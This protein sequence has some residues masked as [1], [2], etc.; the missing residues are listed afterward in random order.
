M[1]HTVAVEPL[2]APQEEHRHP[3]PAS[4]LVVGIAAVVVGAALAGATTGW[5]P[6]ATH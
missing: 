4:V 3:S 2:I 6:A 5:S 1:R